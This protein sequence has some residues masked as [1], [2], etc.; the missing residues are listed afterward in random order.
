[1]EGLRSA[2]VAGAKSVRSRIRGRLPR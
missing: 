2:A 1:V